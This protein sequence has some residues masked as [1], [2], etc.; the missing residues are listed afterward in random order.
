MGSERLHPDPEL[1]R[2]ITFKDVFSRQTLASFPIK[3]ISSIQM[4]PVYV[5]LHDEQSVV[6]QIS[7]ASAA[8]RLKKRDILFKGNVRVASGARVLTTGQLRMLAEK[9]VI[10]T[11]R[12]F[13]LKRPEKQYEGE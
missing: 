4:E 3:R 6:T 12:H 1:H 5:T 10:K 2:D 7:A 9:A 11:D 13:V 8:I